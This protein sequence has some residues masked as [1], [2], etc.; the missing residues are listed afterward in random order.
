ML[1]RTERLH[2][3]Q[4]HWQKLRDADDAARAAATAAHNARLRAEADY[5]AIRDAPVGAT[6]R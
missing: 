1:T 5:R 2:R 6:E 3:G 4:E